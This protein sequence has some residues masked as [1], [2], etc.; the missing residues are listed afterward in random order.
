MKQDTN[1]IKSR[2][3]LQQTYRWFQARKKIR[4]PPTSTRLRRM[5]AHRLWMEVPNSSKQIH[6]TDLWFSDKRFRVQS[7]HGTTAV[8]RYSPSRHSILLSWINSLFHSHGGIHPSRYH[9]TRTRCVTNNYPTAIVT[10]LPSQQT[11]VVIL[12]PSY[13]SL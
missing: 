4:K 1:P 9:A 13:L 11:Y 8:I 12:S 10:H 5:M 2:H 6:V 3:Q 7:N